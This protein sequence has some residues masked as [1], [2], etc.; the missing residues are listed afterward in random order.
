VLLILKEKHKM[1]YYSTNDKS[2][3]ADFKEATIQGQAPDKGLYYPS[4]IPQ[5]DKKFIEGIENLSREAIA[6]KVIEPYV[7][8]TIP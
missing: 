7:G 4:E 1:Y 2:I 8:N 5:L 3:K 6:L